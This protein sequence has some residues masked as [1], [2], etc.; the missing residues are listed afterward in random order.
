MIT[1]KC[2]NCGGTV[3]IGSSGS[4]VCE[5]C[6]SKSFMT[7]A[8][9]KGN[10]DF[11]KKLLTSLK[12]EAN[13]KEF[14]YTADLMWRNNETISFTMENGQALTISYM[15]SYDYK[16]CTCYLAKE[17]IVYV[18]DSRSEKDAFLTGTR[19]LVFPEADGKLNRCFPE[20]KMDINL[21]DGRAVLVFI[22]RPNFYPVELFS[23]LLSVHLAWVI[24]RMENICCE[25]KYSGITHGKI[26]PSSI[27]INPITHEGALFGDWR[28]VRTLSDKT[29]LK[30]LRRTAIE[31]ASNSRSPIELY[32]FLNSSPADNAFEDFEKWDT[33]IE[34]GF[35]GHK[36]VK[37]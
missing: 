22:R 21:K 26:D 18:F 17:N 5:F 19:K 37:M 13:E 36:F 7:D 2:K 32:E 23:P 20:F 9:Y 27:W 12:A 11:R 34:R 16:G 35:G 28:H 24:S 8:D 29:D 6:G 10:E 25:L 30:S 14:D 31:L 15:Y 33:V 1:Y 4:I 3:K